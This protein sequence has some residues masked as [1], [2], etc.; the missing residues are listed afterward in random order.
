MTAA[1]VSEVRSWMD[2]STSLFI[3]AIDRLS[4]ASFN[5][6]SELPGWTIAAVVA[7]GETC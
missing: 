2:E 1:D 6:P 3:G 7:H 5:N 4:D